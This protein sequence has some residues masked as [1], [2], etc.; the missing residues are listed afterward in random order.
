MDFSVQ[1]VIRRLAIS[2]CKYVM[3]MCQSMPPFCGLC[4]LCAAPTIMG[5]L[6]GIERRAF[7]CPEDY[8]LLMELE[9]ARKGTVLELIG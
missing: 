5:V 6:M 2:L 9:L 8:Y 4:S 3:T 1:S 7:Y